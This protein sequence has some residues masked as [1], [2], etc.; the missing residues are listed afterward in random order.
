MIR[1]PCDFEIL[2]KDKLHVCNIY[3]ILQVCTQMHRRVHEQRQRDFCLP[4]AWLPA[5]TAT[6]AETLYTTQNMKIL[7]FAMG[8]CRLAGSAL[9]RA[10]PAG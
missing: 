4:E 9:Y 7:G 5:D 2:T 3:L 8:R 10:G 6:H 1:L